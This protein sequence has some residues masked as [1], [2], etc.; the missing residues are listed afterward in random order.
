MTP[1]EI[2]GYHIALSFFLD[3]IIGDPRGFPHPVSGIGKIISIYEEPFRRLK[4]FSEK[5]K[6]ILFFF[7]VNLTV[8]LITLFFLL[9]LE[10]LKNN[11][12]MLSEVLFIFTIS[13]FLALKGLI[14]TGLKIEEYLQKKEIA[15]AR[16]E[17]K[18]LVGRDTDNLEKNSIR[19]AI[20]ESYGENLNDGVIAPL[21]WLS[22]FGLPGIIFYKTVNTLDSM[23]GYKNER[24]IHFGWFSAKMDD[25]LNFIPARLT[26]LLIVLSSSIYFGISSGCRALKWTFRYGPK[27]P[28]PN[29]GYPEAALAGALGVRL[30][31]PA[32]YGGKLVE[33]PYLGEDYL[34]NLEQAI[35]LAK[36]LL[37]LSSFFMLF[38]ILI[39][40][41][42]K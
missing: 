10:S 22:L 19:K 17:L 41:G 2:K 3:L 6:G 31:G 11:Y 26:A 9:I 20:L 42:L 4:I 15:L 29:S 1:F 38:I 37:Y 18:A 30:L 16:G 25:L 12:F 36:N 7:A 32:Y 23:V 33:K 40:K 13:L 28:S 21:F 14:T 8:L 5:V 27:H 24:Y 34:T 35:P 39:F